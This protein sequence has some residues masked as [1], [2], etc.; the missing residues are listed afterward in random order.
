L[1][2]YVHLFIA[3]FTYSLVYSII[4]SIIQLLFPFCVK[5][6]FEAAWYQLQ[7]LFGLF[8]HF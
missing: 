6:V 3:H 2:N 1:D 4:Y 5:Y 8:L 7:P